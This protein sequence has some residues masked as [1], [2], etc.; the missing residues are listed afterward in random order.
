MKAAITALHRSQPF[1]PIPD[2]AKAFIIDANPLALPLRMHRHCIHP[3]FYPFRIP[4]LCM[5][6]IDARC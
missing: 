1:S 5:T 3:V 2:S 4:P 6:F